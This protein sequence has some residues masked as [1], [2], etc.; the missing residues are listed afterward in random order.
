MTS[1]VPNG[2]HQALVSATVFLAGITFAYLKF[3]VV[4]GSTQDWT[5]LAA[6]SA[7]LAIAAVL[8]QAETLRRSLQLANDDPAR[9]TRSARF[10]MSSVWL[11]L[12]SALALVLAQW[13]HPFP[14][15]VDWMNRVAG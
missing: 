11:L 8:V 9:Y 4:D 13:W 3:I 12:G 6:L 1:Q 5:L 7:L 14:G 15:L 2:F 10:L